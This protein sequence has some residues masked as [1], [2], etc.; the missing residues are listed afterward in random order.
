MVPHLLAGLTA[1]VLP[2]TAHEGVP[3]IVLQAQATGTPVIGTRV[4]GIPQVVADGETGL[5]V[6]PHDPA[7]LAAAMQAVLDD[8]AAA[9]RRAEKA[10]ARVR[11]ENS[12]D[13][14]GEKLETMYRERLG[15][16]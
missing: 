9:V 4:G 14:M 15:L 12:L 13:A 10:L 16:L 3:Q 6:P 11:A 1:L 8:P 5:L 2:S 7:A